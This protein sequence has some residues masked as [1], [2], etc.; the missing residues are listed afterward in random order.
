MRGALCACAKLAGTSPS[1]H[2][3]KIVHNTTTLQEDVLVKQLVVSPRRGP[4]A[5]HKVRVL[6][7]FAC[8]GQDE[9]SSPT[10]DALASLKPCF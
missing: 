9:I 8:E 6:V 1:G 7:S 5:Q 3:R 10:G 4:V 2:V